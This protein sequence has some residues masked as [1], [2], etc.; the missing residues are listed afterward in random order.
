MMQTNEVA[1]LENENTQDYVK[2]L[3]FLKMGSGRSLTKAFKQYYETTEE[4]SQTWQTLAD[5]YQWQDRA[6]QYDRAVQQ[7]KK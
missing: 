5:K 6:A 7:A 2:F 4:V 3:V 1:Q